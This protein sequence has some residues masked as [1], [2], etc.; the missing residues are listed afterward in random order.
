MNKQIF[1]DKGKL[2]SEEVPNLTCRSGEI[3][4]DVLF[5]TFSSGTEFEEIVKSS[6]SLLERA[7]KSPQKISKV[8]EMIKSTGIKN[9]INYI[10]DSQLS[11]VSTGYS[12]AGTVVSIGSGIT[13]F[14][15]GDLVACSGAQY[16]HHANQVKV[17]RQLCT[18]IPIGLSLSLASTVTLG[19]I[20]MQGIRQANISLGEKVAVIGLGVIGQIASQILLAAGA[21]VT[22]IDLE[23]Q[24][25]SLAS[26]CGV[27]NILNVKSSDFLK[28]AIEI[29]EGHGFDKVLICSSDQS[30]SSVKTAFELARH[31][32]TVVMIGN[33]S[34]DLDRRLMYY[35]ELNF[36][37][38]MSYGPGRYERQY[39]EKGLDLPIAYV[40]WTENRNMMSY[41][42]VLKNNYDKIEKL[43]GKIVDFKDAVQYLNSEQSKN[44]K[45]PIIII[46]YP[47]QTDNISTKKVQ[48]DHIKFNNINNNITSI[49]VVGAGGFVKNFILPNFDRIKRTNI[50]LLVSNDTASL[51]NMKKKYNIHS[52]FSD[53]DEALEQSID[54][55]II[56][57]RHSEHYSCLQKSL[58]KNK[59]VFVEKPTVNTIEELDKLSKILKDPKYNH[60]KIYTGYNR[61]YSPHIKFIKNELK[62]INSPSI[63][64]YQ[65]NAGLLK[66]QNWQYDIE[67][68]GRNIGEAVHIYHLFSSLFQS[69]VK[70]LSVTSTNG[71]MLYKPGDNF[72]VT[73]RYENGC[74]GI[75]NYTSLGSE[76]YPKESFVIHSGGKTIIS[77]NYKN[78]KVLG[79]KSFKTSISE[80][81]H[82]E[83]LES[84]VDSIVSGDC[85]MSR[86]EQL[87]TIKVAFYVERELREK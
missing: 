27:Q 81:G 75:L 11:L 19:S 73:L 2:V 58:L 68:G 65:M 12:I 22:G 63:I 50:S 24:K 72:V 13:D 62:N 20:A 53:I 70:S 9:T 78:S 32:A 10:Q 60:L 4:V 82:R 6:K 77:E 3:I 21:N 43:I 67:E 71:S 18:K 45:K 80:K 29:T 8:V 33:I 25:L 40:R 55:I 36:V 61:A 79:G 48:T 83:I 76:L 38:S 44:L 74:I 30:S 1:I 31:R 41:L 46:K 42:E 23:D 7:R 66:N 85:H 84:F 59:N 51:I 86:E 28:R 34:L 52:I 5:S 47:T 17:S 39:E 64:S 35:K 54:G 87:E 37:A 26:E 57:N 49:G 56:C 16:A 14:A 15:I 69:K